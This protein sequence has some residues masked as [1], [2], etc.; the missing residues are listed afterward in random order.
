M[1]AISF[2]STI[3]R[4]RRRQA[5]LHTRCINITHNQRTNTILVHYYTAYN[6]ISHMRFLD[7]G[8]RPKSEDLVLDKSAFGRLSCAQ[9]SGCVLV[10]P[11]LLKRYG[12][13]GLVAPK[14]IRVWMTPMKY[15]PAKTVRPK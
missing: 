5:S 1:C 7:K 12:I 14:L 13:G 8:F 10:E 4:M 2:L 11:G 9:I 3:E 6:M 15:P